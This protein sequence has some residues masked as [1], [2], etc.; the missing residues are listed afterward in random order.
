MAS[1]TGTSADNTRNGTSAADTFDM[2]QGGN[3]TVNGGGGNDI[4]S[5]ADTFSSQDTV[6]GGAGNDTVTLVGDYASLVLLD[7]SLQSVEQLQF[8]AGHS[9]SITLAAGNIAAG[10]SMHIDAHTLG[11]TDTTT[12]NGSVVGGGLYFTGGSG[13]DIVLGG[14]GPNYF[15]LSAGGADSVR[16]GASNDT[17]YVAGGLDQMSLDGADG[18]DM[19]IVNGEGYDSKAPLQLQVS[20]ISNIEEMDF[21]GGHSYGVKL[22]NGNLLSGRLTVQFIGALAT[23]HLTFDASNVQFGRVNVTGGAGDDRLIGGANIDLFDLSLGGNDVAKGGDGQKNFF[24]MGAALNADDVIVGGNI[25][26]QATLDGDYA[27][28][29]VI[30]NATTMR[31]VHNIILTVGHSYTLSLHEKTVAAG[32]YLTIGGADL[33]SVNVM[34]ID[35][36]ADSN[37]HLLMYGGAAGDTLIGGGGDDELSGGLGADILVTGGGN[38]VIHYFGVAQST[39]TGFDTIQAFNFTKD[40]FDL[41]VAVAGIDGPVR[42]G[43]LNDA[44]FD[45]DL[46][47]AVSAARLAAGHAVRFAPNAGDHAGENFLVVDANGIAGYQAGEDYVFKLVHGVNSTSLDIADFT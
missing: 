1:Y 37:G 29:P 9:Y 40:H 25:F 27:T 36:S 30:F 26:D 10:R 32:Q 4:V 35:G 15:D 43:Q 7:T 31:N 6:N 44:S 38:D 3:D 2:T 14:A 19:L 42:K 39:G 21:I 8:G 33:N 18:R 20:S 23:D 22:D 5:F 17:F 11:V 34:T 16:G 24:V 45:I 41:D 47:A 12:I 28:A 46:T 13:T